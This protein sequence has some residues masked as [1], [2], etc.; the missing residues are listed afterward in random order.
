[1]IYEWY[2][3]CLIEVLIVQICG[4]LSRIK[5]LLIGFG[6]RYGP[7]KNKGRAADSQIRFTCSQYGHFDAGIKC[8][9]LIFLAAKLRESPS[10]QPG[11]LE[12]SVPAATLNLF[13]TI[14]CLPVAVLLEKQTNYTQKPRKNGQKTTNINGKISS[15]MTCRHD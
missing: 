5:K 1:M 3:L 14:V 2:S 8:S 6:Q 12:F 4:F 7:A 15:K 9:R 10:N 11:L 13:L